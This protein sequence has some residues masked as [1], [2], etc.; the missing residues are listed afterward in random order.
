MLCL[1]PE[2]WR[3]EYGLGL[4]PANRAATAA[5]T[6]HHTVEAAGERVAGGSILLGWVVAAMSLLVLLA[7]VG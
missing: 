3:L 6:R 2:L 5:G 7:W 4:K 1:C